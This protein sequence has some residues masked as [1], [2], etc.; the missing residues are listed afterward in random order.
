LFLRPLAFWNI[1]RKLIPLKIIKLSATASTNDHL[2]ELTRK[3]YPQEAILVYTT[4]QTN[5]RGQLGAQ[6]Y[7]EAG[8]SLAMSLFWP[9]ES[10]SADMLPALG[11]SL[12]LAVKE[13]LEEQLSSGVLLKW[14]NDIMADGRK[15]GGMLVES[16]LRGKHLRSVVVGLGLNINN[17]HFPKDL[18]A[19]SLK[20]LSGKEHDLEAICLVLA[21]KM[22]AAMESLTAQS[23]Q[24]LL[25]RYQEAQYGQGQ[26]RTF[27]TPSGQRFEAIIAGITPKGLLILRD[28]KNVYTNYD[29][30]EIR[31]C[32]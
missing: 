6:W 13:V 26:W 30:K 7:G 17:T 22:C 28:R 20:Q 24:R 4:K 29:L 2:L 25:E 23:G 12:S 21:E 15:L 8:K 16:Q 31:Y 18:R 27:E 1:N 3:E 5:G 10:M 19:V 11:W 14:P 9:F 32:F